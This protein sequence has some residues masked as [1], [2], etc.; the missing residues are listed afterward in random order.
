[1]ASVKYGG[2]RTKISY[3][4]VVQMLNEFARVCFESLCQLE[5]VDRVLILCVYEREIKRGQPKMTLRDQ[6]GPNL[7]ILPT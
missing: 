3:R 6:G 5:S 4:K 1:M 7:L 2:F